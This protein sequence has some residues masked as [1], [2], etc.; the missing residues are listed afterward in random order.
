MEKKINWNIFNR[1]IS[2][3]TRPARS[4]EVNGVDYNFTNN[5][6]FDKKLAN[7]GYYEHTVYVRPNGDK[8]QYGMSAGQVLAD[9][10]NLTV[11]NPHGAKQLKQSPI[12][13]KLKIVLIKSDRDVRI[14]RYLAR[15][16]GDE[17]VIKANLEK[18]L[19]DDDKDFMGKDAE[20]LTGASKSIVYYNNG[21]NIE[22]YFNDLT[23][24]ILNDLEVKEGDV[25][26]LVGEAA[27]GKTEYEKFIIKMQRM[28]GGI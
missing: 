18:R 16:T 28:Q 21:T 17:T 1:M 22:E 27:V 9:K 10:V 23:S 25:V 7:G 3:T 8:W 11:V 6:N 4:N 13:D 2:D 26:A 15:E 12:A 14:A 20:I 5:A 24:K 19:A